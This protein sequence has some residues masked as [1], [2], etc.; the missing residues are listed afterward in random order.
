VEEV[1][2]AEA[3]TVDELR[4]PLGQGE[5]AGV[6][7]DQ[8]PWRARWERLRRRRSR[9]GLRLGWDGHG[10]AHLPERASSA[11]DTSVFD[12]SLR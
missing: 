4:E 9:S 11:S 3:A 7:G 10:D 8:R 2:N 1:F 12:V 5:G 6:G